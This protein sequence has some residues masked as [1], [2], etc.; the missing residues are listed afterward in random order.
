MK[1]TS[2]AFHSVK[3]NFKKGNDCY[4]RKIYKERCTEP[5]Y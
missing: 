5:Y 4:D 2:P 3:N 1:K